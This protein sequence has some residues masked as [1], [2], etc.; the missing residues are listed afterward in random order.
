MR[1]ETGGGGVRVAFVHDFLVD[2]RGAERVLLA[3]C[4]L[5]P[6]AARALVVTATEEFGIAA[7]GAP[8][9]GRPVIARAEGGGRETVIA[10]E[11]GTFSDRR[12]PDARA[13]AVASFDPLSVDPQAC[14]RNVERFDVARVRHGVRA[15]VDRALA[16]VGRGENPARR[17]APRRRAGLAWQA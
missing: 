8:A 17:R 14:A 13:A 7:V 5:L 12:D 6:A 9:A 3:L 11:S 1:E 2:V 16:T 4:D 10:G 15:V